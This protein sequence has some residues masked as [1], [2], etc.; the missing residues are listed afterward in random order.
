M[1]RTAS[2][3]LDLAS[4]ALAI[5]ETTAAKKWYRQAMDELLALERLR[6]PVLKVK[7]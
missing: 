7:E 2:V 3:D 4:R 5:G 1:L 6:H